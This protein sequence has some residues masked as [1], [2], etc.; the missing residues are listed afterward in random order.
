VLDGHGRSATRADIEASRDKS[1]ENTNLLVRGIGDLVQLL[2]GLDLLCAVGVLLSTRLHNGSQVLEDA[3]GSVLE[4]AATLANGSKT[5]VVALLSRSSINVERDLL[6]LGGR[7]NGLVLGRVHEGILVRSVGID[8]ALVFLVG[9]LDLLLDGVERSGLDGVHLLGGD[10]LLGE[11]L[12]HEVLKLG[13]DTDVGLGGS[14]ARQLG[15]LT[16]KLLI[17][18]FV[19]SF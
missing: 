2:H 17:F 13:E 3:L 16:V 10:L 7:S 15:D 5:I 11:G 1:K 6:G 18:Y 12:V 14:A 19:V 8:L 9:L 4:C